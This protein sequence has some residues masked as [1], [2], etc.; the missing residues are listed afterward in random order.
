[1]KWRPASR[2]SARRLTIC[3]SCF[4]RP[5]T[6]HTL[7]ATDHLDMI[8]NIAVPG[9]ASSRTTDPRICFGDGE[10][11]GSAGEKEVRHNLGRPREQKPS[12]GRIRSG[13]YLR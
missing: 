5:W 11:G 2:K 9:P 4:A 7:Y 8:A 3:F 6:F 12:R 10:Q 1:M 13:V